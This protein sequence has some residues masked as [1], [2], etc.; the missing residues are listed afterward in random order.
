MKLVSHLSVGAAALAVGAVG[1]ATVTAQQD[2]PAAAPVADARSEQ[3]RTVVVTRTI[4]RTRHVRARAHAVAPRA[5]APVVQ[6]APAVRAAPSQP[7]AAPVRTRSSGGYG[8]GSDEHE[9]SDDGGETD[10]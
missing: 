3:V 2:R 8:S 4:H 1:A 6:A 7:A 5:T 9:R 10:D